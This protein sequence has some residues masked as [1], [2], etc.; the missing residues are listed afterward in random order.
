MSSGLEAVI[1]KGFLAIAKPW[2]MGAAG[3]QL[4]LPGWEAVIV[5]LPA[6]SMRALGPAMI[7]QG[8]SALSSTARPELADA[9]SV[10]APSPYVWSAGPSKLIVWEL[11]A[12]VKDRATSGAPA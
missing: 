5:Q 9:S 3:F 2:L 7:V 10:T 4:P 6:P 11:F 1:V 12:I 8:P